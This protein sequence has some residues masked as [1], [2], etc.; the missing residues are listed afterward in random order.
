MWKHAIYYNYYQ[1]S[2]GMYCISWLYLGLWS[3]A[4]YMYMFSHFTS[5]RTTTRCIQ[6]IMKVIKWSKARK[7]H[8]GDLFYNTLRAHNK[9]AW[10]K[11][12]FLESFHE[13]TNDCVCW[14]MTILSDTKSKTGIWVSC[15]QVCWWNSVYRYYVV[16]SWHWCTVAVQNKHFQSVINIL[17]I[18]SWV[19][20]FAAYYSR[21]W[22]HFSSLQV[23]KRKSNQS[24]P[25]VPFCISNV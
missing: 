12:F 14:K 18:V 11:S 17:I 23:S 13:W 24:K 22:M 9:L 25:V 16:W 2:R 21:A 8:S 20:S 3:C 5:A 10:M 15:M 19:H 1:F 7:I 6:K 4:E